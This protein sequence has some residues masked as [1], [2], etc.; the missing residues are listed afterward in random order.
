MNTNGIIKMLLAVI[1][2]T[3]A[4]QPGIVRA[5][6]PVKAQAEMIEAKK[7][8]LNGHEWE[9]K[10]TSSADKTK[11]TTDTLYF[12]DMKFE[13]KNM[14]AQGYNTTNYTIALQE[15]GP[16]VWET[17]QSNDKGMAVFWR[18]E[19]QGDSMHGL[20]S[21]QVGEGK[22]EDYFFASVTSKEIPAE[23]PKPVEEVPAAVTAETAAADQAAAPATDAPAEAVKAVEAAA[24]EVKAEAPKV[25][26]EVKAAVKEEK[27]KKKKGWF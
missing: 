12:R 27:P 9:I 26:A 7:K 17:M 23:T 18:A 8:E 24:A 1:A 5:A 20:M 11:I 21:K 4:V 10:V 19:W 15:G 2:V 16:S 14:T 3:F 13:S 22:N 25:E 6:D